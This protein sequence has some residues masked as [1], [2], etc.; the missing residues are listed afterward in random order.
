MQNV[1]RPAFGPSLT[2]VDRARRT[3]WGLVY[4]ALFVGWSVGVSLAVYFLTSWSVPTKMIVAQVIAGAGGLLI[5]NSLIRRVR[6]EGE[7][8]P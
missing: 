6:Q 4:F 7:Q 3:R 1:R 5:V 8:S 2:A